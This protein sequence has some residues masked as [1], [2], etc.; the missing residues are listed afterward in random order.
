VALSFS[1]KTRTAALV[2]GGASLAAAATTTLL[3]RARAL[4]LR[5]KVVVVTGGSRGLGLLLAEEFGR[6]GASLAICGRD[7]DAVERAQRWLMGHGFEV[8]AE[9]RDIGDPAAAGA[10]VERIIER[11]GRLDVLVNNAGVIHVAPFGD[12]TRGMIEEAMHA[13]FWSAVNM[14]YA[15]LPHLRKQGAGG[16]IVNITSVGGRVAI[17]HLI[18]YTASKFA[19]VGLSEALRAELAP[20]GVKVTTVVPGLMR[21]GSYYNAEFLGHQ[22]QEF[23]WFSAFAAM[24]IVSID[25]EVAA[26]RIVRA[27]REGRVELSFALSGRL[28]AFLHGVAP[29]LTVRLMTLVNALLPGP[30]QSTSPERWKGR[31]INST[32]PG[33]S[34]LRLG[35]IAA[36]HNNEE[37]PV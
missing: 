16:R 23:D 31:E 37:P 12:V 36:R 28:P 34:L 30:S 4:D 17:P 33:S 22:R 32:L 2:L 25:A 3:R 1:R 13:N 9:A 26:R 5:G 21:T 18:G 15:A 27:A 10:F 29:R 6:Q 24:P 35:D 7:K 8:F 14:T 19:M 11:Y 20:Y